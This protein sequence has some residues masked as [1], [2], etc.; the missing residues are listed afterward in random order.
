M[1]NLGRKNE[2]GGKNMNK[3]TIWNA[4][5]DVTSVIS[6]MVTTFKALKTVKKE[7]A[8]KLKER[9]KVIESIS[10]T[11]GLGEIARANINELAKTQKYIEQ[12]NLNGVAL[13]H[14]ISQLENLGNMLEKNLEDYSNGY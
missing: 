14:A 4:T 8:I 7:D 2:K 3:L 6:S 9:I 1:Y 10:R 13:K 5:K 11:Y 12:C